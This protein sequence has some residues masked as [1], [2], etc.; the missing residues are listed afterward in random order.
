MTV[1]CGILLSNS[2]SLVLFFSPEV[3]FLFYKAST[4]PLPPDTRARGRR[5]IYWQRSIILLLVT[6]EKNLLKKEQV[7]GFDDWKRWL[8]FF[9]KFVPITEV[10][11]RKF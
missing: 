11:K 6:S 9:L 2:Y 8:K 1:V 7:Q 4:G 3:P 10:P 5:A